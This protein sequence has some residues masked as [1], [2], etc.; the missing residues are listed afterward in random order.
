MNCTFSGSLTM[1]LS[2]RRMGG[3]GN[4]FKDDGQYKET[5]SAG[6]FG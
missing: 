1:S 6:E 3:V 2:I 4:R 5:Q